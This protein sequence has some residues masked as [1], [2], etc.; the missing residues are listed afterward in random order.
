MEKKREWLRILNYKLVV[1]AYETTRDSANLVACQRCEM[2]G[3]FALKSF[4]IFKSLFFCF[5]P[6]GETF[7]PQDP[8][9]NYLTFK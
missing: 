9:P 4:K 6:R 1:V 5:F 3:K 7:G 2:F 8:Y